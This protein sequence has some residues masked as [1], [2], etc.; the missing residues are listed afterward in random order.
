MGD[1]G[2]AVTGMS[3]FVSTLTTG[4]S[5]DALWGAIAPAGALILIL[6]LFALGKRVLNKNI[7]GANK[8]T[9]G[10]I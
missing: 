8:G 5:A 10:K 2:S 7:K 6:T 3:S 1:A 4:L 9:G